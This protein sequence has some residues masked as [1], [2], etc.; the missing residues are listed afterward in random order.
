MMS[1]VI[2]SFFTSLQVPVYF[3]FQLPITKC[4]KHLTSEEAFIIHE[5]NICPF[6]IFKLNRGCFYKYGSGKIL[7]HMAS[8]VEKFTFVCIV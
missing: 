4:D 5:L 1:I 8:D 7:N 6:Q 3:P 2:D